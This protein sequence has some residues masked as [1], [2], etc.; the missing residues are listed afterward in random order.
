[1][2]CYHPAYARN[3]KSWV[4]NPKSLCKVLVK[5]RKARS[6]PTR[7][8]DPEAERVEQHFQACGKAAMK[9]AFIR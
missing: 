6:Q 4:S 2:R 9:A 7:K 1:V 8:S 3:V 5:R